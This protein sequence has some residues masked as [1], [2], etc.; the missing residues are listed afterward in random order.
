MEPH[1]SVSKFNELIN[2]TL[3]A[4][5]DIAVEGE[6]TQMNIS[7]KGGVN[8]VMKD[9][10]ESAVLNITGYA[11]RIEGINMVNEGMKVVA[12]GV[13][14]LWS[15]GGKFSLAIYKIMPVGAGALREAYEKLKAQLRIEG[16]FEV[17]RKRALPELVTKIALITGKE[18][19]AQ[20]DFLKI[21][22]ENK[23]G[24]SVDIYNVLVQ[25]KHA[26]EE[27]ISALKYA[28]LIGLDAIFLIRGG[29]S[30]EDL[31]TFNSELVARTIFSMKTPVVVGVGHE[32]DESIADFVADIRASTPSQ[33]AYYLAMHNE[34]YIDAQIVK[35]EFIASRLRMQNERSYAYT[36]SLYNRLSSIIKL[37]SSE[38]K[39][40]INRID[41]IL[42]GFNIYCHRL[43]DKVDN[44]LRLLDSFDPKRA[45]KRGY[46]LAR[47][48]GRIIRDAST[49]H[50]D[51]NLDIEL[52]K[53]DI[54]SRIVKINSSNNNNNNNN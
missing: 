15:M 23:V 29:G 43:F 1:F 30:L 4:L 53:G 16:L 32:K 47:S 27:I 37:Q 13:P 52:Y 31:I 44:I 2:S 3:G 14:T 24:V 5:G 46:S 48:N 7:Q 17:S 10:N 11:P 22:K 41:N 40:E 8:L 26:Q 49:L 38:Y 25:G 19:A 6:I 21:I 36:K 20:S 9:P 39:N 34:K 35:C 12:F 50:V 28:D 54:T 45:L 42:E 18:S 33:A 51:M